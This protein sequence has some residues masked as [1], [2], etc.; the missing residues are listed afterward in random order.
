MSGAAST[1][2]WLTCAGTGG[3]AV[4]L[5]LLK[6][7]LDTEPVTPRRESH[8]S[9]PDPVAP[10]AEAPARHAGPPQLDETHPLIR[11]QPTRA[12]HSKGPAVTWT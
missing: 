5:G 3:G 6:L 9:R 12:R 8:A 2:Q 7:A 1:A 10:A 11:F 4:A